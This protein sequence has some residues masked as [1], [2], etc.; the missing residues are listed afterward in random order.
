MSTAV[1]VK[2]R[3]RFFRLRKMTWALIVWSALWLLLG[4]VGGSSGTSAASYCD[5]HGSPRGSI[6]RQTCIDAYH[7]GTGIGVFLIVVLWFLG[8]VVLSLVWFMSRPRDV[9]RAQPV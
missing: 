2:P 5:T 3:G 9:V 1:A 8:F 4:I 7:T 6:G